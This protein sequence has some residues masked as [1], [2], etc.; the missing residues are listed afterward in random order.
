MGL[1]YRH[2]GKAYHHRAGK[3]MTAERQ[4][5]Q[6]AEAWNGKSRRA[7]VHSP[8]RN[9]PSDRPRPRLRPHPD[10]P[11]WLQGFR[12]IRNKLRTCG[13]PAGGPKKDPGCTHKR[14][15]LIQ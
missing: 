2:H 15:Q 8:I 11:L 12:L 10:N 3:L 13:G 6:I 7:A 14:I 9:G 4:M 5:R 1:E